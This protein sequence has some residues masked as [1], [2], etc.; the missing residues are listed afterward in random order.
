MANQ[1]YQQNCHKWQT[2]PPFTVGLP[3]T[4]ER[5]SASF[6]VTRLFHKVTVSQCD[7]FFA[8]TYV[9]VLN[10]TRLITRLK[11]FVLFFWF[12]FILDLVGEHSARMHLLLAPYT[13][14]YAAEGISA[15]QTSLLFKYMLMFL[16]N[17]LARKELICHLLWLT[18]DH[19][20]YYVILP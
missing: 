5:Y 16:I 3:V 12:L 18:I 4:S 9:F 14:L 15:F 8:A 6:Q 10:V 2:W 11:S 1:R 13:D 7:H 17:K 20:D 19:H